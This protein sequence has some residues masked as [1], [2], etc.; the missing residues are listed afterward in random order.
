MDLG[1]THFSQVLHGH[2]S[3]AETVTIIRIRRSLRGPVVL[4]NPA[5]RDGQDPRIDA[6]CLLVD[7]ATKRQTVGGKF[8]PRLQDENPCNRLRRRAISQVSF[9]TPHRECGQAG[10]RPSATAPLQQ[11]CSSQDKSH[12]RLRV[13]SWVNQTML[14]ASRSN[15]S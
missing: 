10:R 13:Q 2:P 5:L 3:M 12:Q 1:A 4:F 7:S 6:W 9:R 11:V 15:R 8:W 14:Y